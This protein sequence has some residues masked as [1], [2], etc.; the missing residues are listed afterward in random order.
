MKY[1]LTLLTVGIIICVVSTNIF[2]NSND[3]LFSKNVYGHTFT[4][5]ESVSFLSFTEQLQIESELV[6][7]NLANNNISLAEEHVEKAAMLLT[8]NITREIAEENKRIADELT[9]AVS[10][11]QNI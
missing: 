2:D 9:I 11:I 8:P 10:S 5:S 3:P 1:S 7:T 4:P 6:E